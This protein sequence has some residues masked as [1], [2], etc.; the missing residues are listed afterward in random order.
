[1]TIEGKRVLITGGAGFIGSHLVDR[2]LQDGPED[3]VVVDN[4]YLGNADNIESA[5]SRF[6]DLRVY[7]IDASNPS[8]MQDIA[9]RHAIDV[10]YSLAV[11]PLVTSLDFPAWTVDVN[12]SLA[13]TAC[14]LVRRGLVERL[15]HCSSSEVYGSAQMVPMT[16]DHVLGAETPYA[17]SKAAG[18]LIVQSFVKTFG[19][20]ATVLRP[21][22]NFGPRQNADAYAGVIPIVIRRVLRG[23]PIEIHG[24]GNQTRDF[25][26]V[27]QTADLLVQA[28]SQGSRDGTPVNI[29]SGIET[30]INELVSRILN[31][32]G[33]AD[34]P[35]IHTSPRPGD[36]L[37]HSAGISRSEQLFHFQQRPISDAD[38]LETIEWY[39]E[40]FA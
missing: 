37:R 12:T 26:Y 22:N 13:T 14:E 4:F 40:F 19:I 2:V 9:Q 11:V 29:G 33:R 15:V 36:V 16:E 5:K 35:I 39:L 28:Y 23:V 27:K 7:R 25:I 20:D 38:L 31:L 17:A 21:F 18:D 8:T 30:S 34:H 32:M 3:L 10:V 24:D 6:R 1:M